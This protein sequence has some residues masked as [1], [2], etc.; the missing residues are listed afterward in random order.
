MSIDEFMR[1]VFEG[2]LQRLQKRF[3]VAAYSNGSLDRAAFER[4]FRHYDRHN[5]GELTFD[6]FRRAARKDMQV[7]THRSALLFVGT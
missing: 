5:S 6:D 1:I 7:T 2:K 4:L 3:Q